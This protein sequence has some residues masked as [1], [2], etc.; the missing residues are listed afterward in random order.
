MIF[1]H[2]NVTLK[3]CS[4]FYQAFFI[5]C[6][7]TQCFQRIYNKISNKFFKNVKHGTIDFTIYFKTSIHYLR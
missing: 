4:K 1:N 7:G 6:P 5:K 2:N 3:E